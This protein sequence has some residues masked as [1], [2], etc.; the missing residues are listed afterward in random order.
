LATRERAEGPG[1]GCLRAAFADTAWNGVLLLSTSD[2]S[3][4]AAMVFRLEE[5]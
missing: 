3:E 5:G 2:E 1:L 4:E